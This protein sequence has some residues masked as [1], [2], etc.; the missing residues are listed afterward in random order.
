MLE[1][2][3][4]LNVLESE[5]HG[6]DY[7]GVSLQETAGEGAPAHLVNF[8]GTV[9]VL[10]ITIIPQDTRSVPYHSVPTWGKDF[11]KDTFEHIITQPVS[12]VSRAMAFIKCVKKC[13]VKARDI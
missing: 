2:F 3:G 13:G 6:F 10:E 9:T 4:N 7:R 1:T 12:M 8:K 11:E 5:L